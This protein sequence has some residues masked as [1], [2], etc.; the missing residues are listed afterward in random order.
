MI[1]IDSPYV[2]PHIVKEIAVTLEVHGY[3]IVTSLR[4]QTDS[5]L[6]VATVYAYGAIGILEA[7]MSLMRMQLKS[8]IK[9]EFFS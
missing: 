1:A 7:C 6:A 9:V 3:N 4:C 5:R 8:L 2:N